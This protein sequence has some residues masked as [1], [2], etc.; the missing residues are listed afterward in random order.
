MRTRFAPSPTGNL[1]IGNARVALIAFCHAQS[2]NGEL[3]LR[4]DDTDIARSK[5]SYIQTIK[6][7][8]KWLGITYSDCFHQSSRLNRYN[9]VLNDLIDRGYVYPCYETEEELDL[10][11]QI[12]MKQ[13]LPPIYHQDKMK[14][15]NNNTFGRLPHYRF[16]VNKINSI[17][18]WND[19]VRNNISFNSKDLSDPIIVRPD[20]SFTYLLPSVIDDIDYNITDIIRGEDHISNTAIQILMIKALNSEIPKFGH[21]SLLKSKTGKISKRIGGFSIDDFRTIH[22]VEAL[23]VAQYLLRLGLNDVYYE[24]NDKISDIIKIFDL[25]NYSSSVAIFDLDSLLNLNSKIIAN[26]SFQDIEGIIGKD[27]ERL[28]N[29][30]KGNIAKLSDIEK[31]QLILNADI[32]NTTSLPIETINNLILTLPDNEEVDKNFYKKWCANI[33]KTLNLKGK[34]LY[35]TL[36]NALT[37]LDNGPDLQGIVLYMGYKNIKKRL[38]N[39]ALYC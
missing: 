19:L 30:I 15:N 2:K 38:N 12:L 18:A 20:G 6:Q 8:L 37:G 24:N 34:N 31:W 32:P 17:I 5:D 9:E 27:L 11:R 10:R 25:N 4:I 35:M 13:G 36:R 22:K 1:H 21:I 39:L 23:T 33:S 28:W 29:L 3:L 7:D 26:L 14:E 16:S